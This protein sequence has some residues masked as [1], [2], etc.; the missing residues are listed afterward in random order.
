MRSARLRRIVRDLHPG[1]R[2]ALCAGFGVAIF[3]EL[4]QSWG[5]PMRSALGWVVGVALWLALIVVAVGHAAP[6]RLRTRARKQD[7]SQWVI[8]PVILGAAAVS[9]AAVIALL[10]KEAGESGAL[11]SLRVAL[12]GGVVVT[13][14]TLIHTVFAVHYAHGFYGDGP[15]PGAADDAGGLQFPGEEELPDF[16]DFFYFSLVI[17]MTCQVS[18]VQIT[19]KHMRRLAS[20]H[21]A[22][23]FFFNTV[24]L[25]LTINF[26]VNAL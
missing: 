2:L 24:I 6:E 26:L 12:A 18:D 21:G 9:L 23:A 20:V 15:K 5:L 11:Q 8:P 3:L 16:W 25:A 4:P 19:G 14:W 7:A 13:S 10:Q 17:G 1:I 22:L